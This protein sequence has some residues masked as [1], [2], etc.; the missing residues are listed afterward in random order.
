VLLI[1]TVVLAALAWRARPQARPVVL[2]AVLLPVA[3]SVAY[4]AVLTPGAASQARY[5]SIALPHVALLPVLAWP[6]LKVRP[7]L[8]GG[9]AVLVAA[10]IINTTLA[11]SDADTPSATTLDGRRPVVMDNLARGVLL[12]IL[13]D[14][15]PS[16]PVYA[17][18]QQTLLSTTDRWL[19]CEEPSPCHERAVTLATQVQYEATA[20]GQVQILTVAADVRDVTPEPSLDDLAQRYLLSAPTTGSVAGSTSLAAGVIHAGR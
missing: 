15:P 1:V 20:E 16:T 4:I 5:F 9:A 11:I 17:A 14:A 13:W 2:L 18:D 7:V 19:H 6:Y 8:V 12:R 10:A 3:L